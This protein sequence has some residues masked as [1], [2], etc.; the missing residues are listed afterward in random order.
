[1]RTPT[2][3]ILH[4]AVAVFVLTAA[5]LTTISVAPQAIAQGS[6][7]GGEIDILTASADQIAKLDGLNRR[8]AR[9]LVNLRDAG[10]IAKVEDLRALKLND[11]R[12]LKLMK[13][14]RAC[15]GNGQYASDLLPGTTCSATDVRINTSSVQSL[16][17][18]IG[19]KN[20]RAVVKA[21][22]IHSLDDIE[23]I[24]K[25]G[26]KILGRLGHRGGSC[27]DPVDAGNFSVS[28]GD[29]TVRVG[30]D[31]RAGRYLTGQVSNCR[32]QRKAG[33]AT[34]S[35]RSIGGAKQ[36]AVDISSTDTAFV[37]S[38]CGTWTR[39]DRAG[40]TTTRTIVGNGDWIVGSQVKPGIY[41]ANR[42]KRCTWSRKSG[43]GGSA[44]EIVA[45]S[46]LPSRKVLVKIERSD[47]AFSSNGCGPWVRIAAACV[48][49]LEA[50]YPAAPNRSPHIYGI[51]DSVLLSTQF[52][53]PRDLP[54]F[55]VSWG[56]WGGLNTPNAPE[57]IAIEVG[58]S[59]VTGSTVIVGLGHNYR[60][61]MDDNPDDNGVVDSYG[62]HIDNVIEAFPAHVT[63]VI[64]VAPSRFNTLMPHVVDELNAAAARHPQMEVADFWIEANAKDH[65]DWYEDEIHLD[66][67]GRNI[68]AQYLRD[69][70][71]KPCG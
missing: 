30:V 65:P 18:R 15:L 37:T 61:W 38:G 20:A 63:R 55:V 57:I 45:G 50:I 60:G 48:N 46:S 69:K 58:E 70:L 9:D 32:W 28:F 52:E 66:E 16:A 43:L 26:T 41:R 47:Q 19:R 13:D 17:K 29:G 49:Q 4:V 25:R 36:S 5:A 42:A 71:L 68:M 24:P 10:R 31:I 11:R 44:S 23:R 39:V 40:L 53:I 51:S 54:E 12:F 7:T 27:L 6:C 59:K 14:S 34:V 56:G 67:E 2:R 3:Q 8:S 21:R 22:P 35:S 33:S 1:M 62:A 64:W